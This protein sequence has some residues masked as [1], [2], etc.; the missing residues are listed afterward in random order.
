MKLLK[1]DRLLLETTK[2]PMVKIDRELFLRKELRDRYRPEVVELAIQYNP[3]YAGIPVEDINQ[4]AKSCIKGEATQ[5]ST[6]SAAAGLP[7]GFAILG[8]LPAD[9]AQY[10]AHIL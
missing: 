2:L 7:G 4:I 1:I 9:L 5:V 8:S 10:F 3:A 6:I